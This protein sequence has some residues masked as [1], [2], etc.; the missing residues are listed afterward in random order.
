[1]MHGQTN[2]KFRYYYL[3]RT[4]LMV[5]QNHSHT[6]RFKAR[7]KNAVQCDLLERTSTHR[8]NAAF[9]CRRRFIL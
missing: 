8:P 1:M 9:S 5:E 2:I 3:L 4:Q 7:V 6:E